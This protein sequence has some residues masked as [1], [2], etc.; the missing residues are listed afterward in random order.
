M[1]LIGD[2]HG[3]FWDYKRI[4]QSSGDKESLVLGDYGLGF[5]NTMDG[6]DLSDVDG[7]H[8]FLRGNHDNP[9]VCRKSPYY[10]GDF[11]IFEGDFID[12]FF[13]K[14]FYIS[15]AWSI[16][17]AWRT[18]GISWWPEEELSYEELDN[19][20]N[21]Y[22]KETPDIV[23]SHDCPEEILQIFY[24][25]TAHPTRTSQALSAMFQHHTPS[26]WFFAHHHKSWRKNV[27]SCNFVCL[28]E[29]ETI[30]ISK[31]IKI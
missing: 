14:L 19:A 10:I 9:E 27:M 22:I 3:L 1:L 4:L 31:R 26:Y 5:P 20:V 2:I 17:Q 11:G 6:I 29:L 8:L 23:C 30:D 28:D 18:P 15:G 13:T 24:S 12:G 7:T 25:G 16:D 21:L